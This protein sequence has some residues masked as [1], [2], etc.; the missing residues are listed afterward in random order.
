MMLPWTVSEIR[1]VCCR[2]DWVICVTATNSSSSFVIILP[3]SLTAPF[4]LSSA[5]WSS[6]HGDRQPMSEEES[7]ILVPCISCFSSSSFL[8]T[9]ICFTSL[10]RVLS[11]FSEFGS[12]DEEEED[13]D[14]DE[15]DEEEEEH[16]EWAVLLCGFSESLLS[17]K[18]EVI[19]VFSLFRPAFFSSSSFFLR[20][21]TTCLAFDLESAQKKK[22]AK[23]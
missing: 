10:L 20:L 1:G 16:E 5:A 4:L 7:L 21:F 9:P 14:E 2:G 11:S 19:S 22:Q 6:T 3:I 8:E 23:K 18:S 13:D 15:D 17:D 12:E